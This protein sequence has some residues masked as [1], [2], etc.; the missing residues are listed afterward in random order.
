MNQT[1]IPNHYV[2]TLTYLGVLCDA[3]RAGNSEALASEIAEDATL[4]ALEECG[5]CPALVETFA[6]GVEPFDV[7]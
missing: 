4:E 2:A 1:R 7:V 3:K 6:T 5:A